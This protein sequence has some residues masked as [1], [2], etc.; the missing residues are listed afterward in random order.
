MS[1]AVR[2]VRLIRAAE[3][4]GP[5]GITGM[6]KSA[7][8]RAIAAGQFPRPIKLTERCV[9]WKSTDVAEWIAA[10]EQK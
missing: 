6:S 9:A 2:D 7:F 4:Y 1:A 5:Q 3:L 10:R 8:Y